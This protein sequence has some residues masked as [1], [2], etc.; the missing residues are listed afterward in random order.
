MQDASDTPRS[1][2]D[3]DGMNPRLA[4]TVALAGV[5][6]VLGCR[7]GRERYETL[8]GRGRGLW[9]RVTVTARAARD[10]AIE[11]WYC[12]EEPAAFARSAPRAAGSVDLLP[13]TLRDVAQPGTTVPTLPQV[14]VTATQEAVEN[15]TPGLRST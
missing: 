8:M 5:A 10:E 11:V 1:I 15:R 14:A 9:M 2:P 3:R 7:A 12:F 4:G 13:R 6:Y